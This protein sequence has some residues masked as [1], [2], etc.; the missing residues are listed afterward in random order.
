MRLASAASS[1]GP[2]GT[3]ARWSNCKKLA[4]GIDREV[5]DAGGHCSQLSGLRGTGASENLQ[6]VDGHL[7]GE[8]AG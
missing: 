4:E 5:V 2:R 1:V 8:D 6:K 3:G 7:I